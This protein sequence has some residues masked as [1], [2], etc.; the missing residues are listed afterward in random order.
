MT[1]SRKLI[2]SMAGL[3]V[4]WSIVATYPVLADDIDLWFIVYPLA[5]VGCGLSAWR[6]AQ[7]ADKRGWL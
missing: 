1:G 7:H 2:A 6:L 4:F 3:W 5:L